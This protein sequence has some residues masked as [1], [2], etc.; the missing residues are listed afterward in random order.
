MSALCEG[1][2]FTVISIWKVIPTSISLRELDN[3]GHF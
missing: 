2:Y 1:G 3:H